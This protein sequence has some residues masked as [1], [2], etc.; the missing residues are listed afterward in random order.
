[1]HPL[2]DL[3][4]ASFGVGFIFVVGAG[5][6]VLDELC[7]RGVDAIVVR[8][9]H[10]V[11]VVVVVVV[12]GLIVPLFCCLSSLGTHGEFRVALNQSSRGEEDVLWCLG[13]PCRFPVPSLEVHV[14]SLA[15]ISRREFPFRHSRRFWWFLTD[16]ELWEAPAR[17]PGQL[18]A[19]DGTM[20]V[21]AG[22]SLNGTKFSSWLL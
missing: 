16:S 21:L 2:Q 3:I 15:T 19:Q 13:I 5:E 1:M 17:M 4:L 8:V 18:R 12:V 9:I 22:T 7:E 14:S 20:A 6:E 10:R 11:A